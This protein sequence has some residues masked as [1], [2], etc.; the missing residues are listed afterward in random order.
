MGKNSIYRVQ[1][2]LQFQ[3]LPGGVGTYSPWIRW[4]ATVLL[5]CFSQ[6]CEHSVN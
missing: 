5:F 2:Y 6:Y 4:G 1:Y 3:A